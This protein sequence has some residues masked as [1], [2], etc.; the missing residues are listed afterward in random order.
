MEPESDGR[1]PAA[2][3]RRRTAARGRNSR[4]G[5]TVGL[6]QCG[7]ELGRGYV[8]LATPHYAG[9]FCMGGCRDVA[10]GEVE[11]SA[12]RAGPCKISQ[13]FFFFK[14]K[15]TIKL[16]L[17]SSNIFLKYLYFIFLFLASNNVF[18]FFLFSFLVVCLNNLFL[19]I[20]G[21]KMNYFKL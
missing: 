16:F 11:K 17:F 4:A 21:F 3:P 14:I 15:L 5:R 19:Q 10:F 18:L 9:Y 1:Q 7:S 2:L 6:R 8:P 20:V 12:A 13:K